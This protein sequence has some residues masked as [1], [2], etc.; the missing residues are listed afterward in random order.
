[1]GNYTISQQAFTIFEK[2]FP[3]D[4]DLETFE[5]YKLTCSNKKYNWIYHLAEEGISGLRNVEDE[6]A[7]VYVR[8]WRFQ[9][10]L[11][12]VFQWGKLVGDD[13]Q[14][15]STR[16]VETVKSRDF[17]NRPGEFGNGHA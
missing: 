5:C 12:G 2:E 11:V 10:V 15:V 8:N 4:T 13:V 6:R 7:L 9:G 14:F 1:M 3:I 16:F 17:M